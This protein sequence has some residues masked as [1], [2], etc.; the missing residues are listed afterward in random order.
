MST[1]YTEFYVQGTAGDN[2]CP[3]DTTANSAAFTYIN[4][5][6]TA[7]WN[8]A[9]GVFTVASGNPS[10]DG[11]LADGTR[12][13]S[14][15]TTSGATV[16]TFVAR[17]TAVSSTTITTSLT[18]YSGTIPTTD[19][20]GALTLKYGGAWKGPNGA[21]G[22]P[23]NFVDGIM[24]NSSNNAV[25]VNF[26]GTFNITAGMTHN[27]VRG[28]TTWRGYSST[29]GD[30]GYTTID[31]GTTG[32]SYALL[33]IGSS[34]VDQKFENFIFQNNGATG[35]AD[36]VLSSGGAEQSF[37]NCIFSNF[38][39]SGLNFQGNCAAVSCE[40]FACQASNTSGYGG[41]TALGSGCAIVACVSHDHVGGSNAN[42][43]T[44]NAAVTLFRCIAAN[45]TGHGFRCDQNEIV[46]VHNCDA[47]NN[48]GSGINITT[49]TPAC[50]VI[51]NCNLF[52]NGG[53][54]IAI[55]NPTTNWNNGVITNC[56]FGSGTQANTSG[57]ITS[58]M[59]GIIE[60][61]SITFPSNLTP[62]K[63]P[64]S[65]DFRTTSQTALTGG[66]NVFTQTMA[67]YGGTSASIGIGA[68]RA[69]PTNYHGTCF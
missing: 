48:T 38:R 56:C 24:T 9:T 27:I 43:F 1:A 5:V 41:F 21:T 33:T 16:A 50:V 36:G 42:G 55:A 14:I 18:A 60:Q 11:I 30:A 44:T 61:N 15:Y 17:V 52:K 66:Y 47:Y 19:A 13:V 32:A 51:T 58:G 23:F 29:V 2:L 37:V 7:S 31:G 3:G 68:C 12:F 10:T 22:F 67:A 28:S 34:T 25:R 62:W 49:T 35:S 40:A 54:G 59:Q 20:T 45:N 39:R 4:A 8:S 57:N 63:N 6:S 46:E 69:Y 53:T 65:G 26:N 64:G